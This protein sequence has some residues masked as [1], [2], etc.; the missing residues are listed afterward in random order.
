MKKLTALFFMISA[1]FIHGCTE[2]QTQELTPAKEFIEVPGRPAS[3]FLSPAVKVGNQL[4]ISGQLGFNY[5][6]N[7]LPDDF[8]GQARQTL[9][10]IDLI[11]KTAGFSLSDVVEAQVFVDDLNNYDAFNEVYVEFFPENPPARAVVEVR[12]LPRDAKIEI[13][14]SAVK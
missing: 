13:K 4:F 12:R 14:L 7:S 9:N 5:E 2:I 1:I 11:L 6:T 10:N 3:P 8:E